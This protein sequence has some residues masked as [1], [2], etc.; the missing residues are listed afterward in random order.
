[1]AGQAV[2]RVRWEYWAA[3]PLLFLGG[4]LAVGGFVLLMSGGSMYYLFAGSSIVL[5][6]AFIWTGRRLGLHIYAAVLLIS[7][8]WACAEVGRDWWQLLPRLDLW[9][10]LGAFLLILLPRLHPRLHRGPA[11]GGKAIVAALCVTMAVGL[12]SLPNEPTD[13][14]GV[15]PTGLGS[16]GT[17]AEIPPLKTSSDDWPSFSG[18]SFSSNYSPLDQITP[19]N[20]GQLQ[21]AWEY[22][23]K[24]L[25]TEHD[26]EEYTNELTPLKVGNTLYLC[27]PHSWAIALDATTGQEKWR[28]DPK[29]KPEADGFKSWPHM[30]CRGVAYYDANLYIASGMD[31]ASARAVSASSCPRRIYLPTAGSELIALNADTGK[32]CDEFA[33]HG[34][35]DLFTEDLDGGQTT[36]PNY[37]S[38]SP[39]IVTANLVIV[40]SHVTDNASTREPS[41]VVRAFDIHTGR[42]VWNWDS[43]NPDQTDPLP[44][45]QHY[46]HNS[47]NVWGLFSADEGRGMVYL[48]MGGQ[49][50]DQWGGE[51]TKG[52]EKYSAGIVALDLATGHVRWNFQFTHHDLWDRD[53]GAAPALVDVKTSDG[54][55]PALI[56]STKEGSIYI[57]DRTNGQPL[58]P[59]HE[60]PV[61]QHPAPGDWNS[62]T[63]PISDANFELPQLKE[64]DMWGVSPFDQLYCRIRFQKMIYQGRY[65]P[66]YLDKE[67]LVSPGN[68][69]VIDWGGV[70]VDV[71]R[72]TLFTNLT[73]VAFVYKLISA[74]DAAKMQRGAS[75]GNGVQLNHGAPFAVEISPFL[76]PWGLPCQAPPW[77][78]VAAMDISNGHI[79]WKHKNGTTRDTA[80]FGIP[81]PLGVPGQGGTVTTKGGVAF[82][83]ATIDNYL[84]GFD[85]RDGK[86]VIRL[87]LPAG[88][89]ATPMSYQGKDG[90]QYIVIMAGGH[91]SLGTQL[92]DSLMAYALPKR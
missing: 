1:M 30:T 47:P 60:L 33:Q 52:A 62:P 69:G 76:T 91:K 34:R 58:V 12:I 57:L 81:L 51:R 25:R 83:G 50:P 70:A 44:P 77:G 26:S 64:K 38:T 23:T 65:T 24:D 7:A 21:L 86:E 31:T 82:V 56:A 71:Q 17:K 37:Y 89:Q 74:H 3:V 61:P 10:A 84:R 4:L 11:H 20:A 35:L 40:G 5:A 87:R 92:G 19:D 22:H 79:F 73:A 68:G 41:G 63:Q 43:A 49:T 15:L 39:P 90:R 88:G 66:P 53:Q 55:K 75:E 54:I 42:L 16:L 59:V 9:F 28:F 27:T 45:G 78:W 6:G 8:L 67:V 72:Q 36:R 32:P 80:P 14:A 29:I 18:T 85:I 46:V 48:P 2:S 13:I